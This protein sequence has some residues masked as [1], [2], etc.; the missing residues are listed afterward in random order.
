[1]SFMAF[2]SMTPLGKGESVSTYVAQ[3][4]DVIDASGVP[5]VVTPMG[6]IL[7][8]DTWDE[9]MNV[10]KK[11]FERMKQDCSRISV[12]IKI[13]YRKSKTGRM[14]AKIT[15]LERKLGKTLPAIE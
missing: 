12:A 7:E 11:G 14:K 6:T 10:L 4:V 5:Y 3:I 9:V 8:G 1:M 13:D 2:V 15:S